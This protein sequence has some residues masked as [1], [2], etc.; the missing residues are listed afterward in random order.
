MA[1]VWT[2]G[3]LQFE[4]GKIR[5]G[6]ANGAQQ[7]LQSFVGGQSRRCSNHQ[8]VSGLASNRKWEWQPIGNHRHRASEGGPGLFGFPR[9]FDDRSCEQP[10]IFPGTLAG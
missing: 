6:E 2:S 9:I 5:Q 7:V 10:A 4:G 3:D 1:A 8:T